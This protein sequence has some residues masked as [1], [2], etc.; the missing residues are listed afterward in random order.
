M[1]PQGDYFNDAISIGSFHAAARGVLVVA[2]AGNE[3]NQGSATN[4]APWMITVAAS[5]TD[6]D[7]ASD[8]T[9]GNAANFSVMLLSSHSKVFL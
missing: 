7:F 3:G 5:S 9:L 1:P 4:L 8:I 6:R 2:S